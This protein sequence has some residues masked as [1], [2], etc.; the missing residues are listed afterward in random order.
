MAL[1]RILAIEL[2][3]KAAELRM[4]N[5][6]AA[7]G[8]WMLVEFCSNLDDPNELLLVGKVRYAYY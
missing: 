5:A 2:R 7:R 1:L 4:K 6:G 3:T 8:R